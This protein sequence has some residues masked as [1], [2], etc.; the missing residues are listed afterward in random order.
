MEEGLAILSKITVLADSSRMLINWIIQYYCETGTLL[1]VIS[2][3]CYYHCYT[4]IEYYECHTTND[5]VSEVTL[6]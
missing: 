4:K 6:S 1:R 2:T 5:P 3:I